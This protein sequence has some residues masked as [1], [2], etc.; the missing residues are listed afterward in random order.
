MAKEM[1]N[2]ERAVK[3]LIFDY[4]VGKTDIDFAVARIVGEIVSKAN[5]QELIDFLQSKIEEKEYCF[6][7]GHKISERK[8]SLSRGLCNTLIKFYRQTGME[9]W[10]TVHIRKHTVNGVRY[11]ETAETTN[12]QKLQYW[13]LARPD[14]QKGYWYL[15]DAGISFVTGRKAIPKFVLVRNNQI[16]GESPDKV[17]ISDVTEVPYWLEKENYDRLEARKELRKLNTK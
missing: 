8:E 16:V 12:F 14:R 4:K 3:T 10:K 9:I 1:N 17:L 15:T 7:C 11:F 6:A 5:R 2:I 13:G